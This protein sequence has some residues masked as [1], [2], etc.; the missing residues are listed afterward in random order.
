MT[1][2]G[3][4]PVGSEAQECPWLHSEPEAWPTREPVSERTV[5]QKPCTKEI[6][7]AGRRMACL[8]Q[9]QS[10]ALVGLTVSILVLFYSLFFACLGG[11]CLKCTLTGHVGFP[12]ALFS[13]VFLETVLH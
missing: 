4:G 9:N 13:S 12:A 11:M 5:R 3:V 1:A 2:L 10:S 7:S 8:R 6:G